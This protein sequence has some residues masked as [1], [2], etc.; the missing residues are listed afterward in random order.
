MTTIPIR[1]S[2]SLTK[3]RDFV[4]DLFR[5]N[6]IQNDELDQLDKINQ[7]DET[8]S[9]TPAESPGTPEKAGELR[10]FRSSG[11]LDVERRRNM[12]WESK[13]LVPDIIN[14][15]EKRKSADLSLKKTLKKLENA[16]SKNK[17]SRI[18]EHIMIIRELIEEEKI[19]KLR[20][21]LTKKIKY[22]RKNFHI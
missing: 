22:S 5:N 12:Y 4:I 11:S 6:R 9:I 21:E 18:F 20:D 7:S 16:Y 15:V 8:K 3:V 19:E 13:Y 2:S 1:K 14:D 17:D 10:N